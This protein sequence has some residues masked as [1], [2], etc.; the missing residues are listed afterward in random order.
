MR[1]TTEKTAQSLILSLKYGRTPLCVEIAKSKSAATKYQNMACAAALCAL[2][3]Y[4]GITTR[5][6]GFRSSLTRRGPVPGT[7]SHVAGLRGKI[8]ISCTLCIVRGKKAG[9][10]GYTKRILD[11]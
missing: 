9:I 7:A 3:N 10:F 5:A 11:L 8:C 6:A 4:V 2:W 1:Y